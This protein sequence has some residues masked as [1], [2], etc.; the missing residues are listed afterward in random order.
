MVQVFRDA[1]SYRVDPFLRC[2]A[3]KPCQGAFQF[4]APSLFVFTGD[5]LAGGLGR[6]PNS[7]IANRKIDPPVGRGLLLAALPFR[8]AGLKKGHRFILLAF[9]STLST[10]LV[11]RNCH[12]TSAG[13]AW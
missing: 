4:A 7:L 2:L 10:Q 13:C 9:A 5:R 1:I 3:W 12:S 11:F 8:V 6:F